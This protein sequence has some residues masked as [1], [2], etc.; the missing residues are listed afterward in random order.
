MQ[1]DWDALLWNQS[2][3]L[4]SLLDEIDDEALDA[5]SLC[6]GWAVRDVIGHMLVGHTTPMPQM[7]RLVLAYRGNIPKGSFEKSKERAASLTAD[8]LR[9]NWREVSEG[10]IRKGISRLV[11]RKEG[12][13]DHF[14]HEQDIR[15]PLDLPAPSD[16]ARLLPALDATVSVNGPMFA[17]AKRVKGVRLEATDVDWQHGVGPVVRGPGEALVMAAAGRSAALAD[18]EGDGVPTLSS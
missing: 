3:A 16:A 9:Q 8:E 1:H 11:P 13:L 18:L 5:P 2:A 17:P 14:V 6:D 12:F 7:L 4:V 10:H 15:R